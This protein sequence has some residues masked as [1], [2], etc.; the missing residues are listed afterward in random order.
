MISYKPL[1]ITLAKKGLKKMDLIEIADISRGTLARLGKGDN[2]AL[3]IIEKIC[4]ALDCRIEEV[5]EILP[6]KN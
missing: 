4:L 6:D 5:V 2:I 3:S 1:M